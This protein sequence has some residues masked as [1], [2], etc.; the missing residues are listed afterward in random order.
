MRKR[1]AGILASLLAGAFLCWGQA[2]QTQ[3]ILLGDPQFGMYATNAGVAQEAA[4]YEFAVATVNRLKPAFVVVLGDLVNKTGDPDQI[5]EFRRITAKVDAAIPVYLLPG[6]HDVGNEPNPETLAAFRKNIGRDYYSFRAGD[7]YGIVLN[8]PLIFAPAKAM[9]DYQEQEAWLRKELETA[10]VSGAKHIILF[11]HHP[12]FTKSA[13]EPD[14]YEN[15]PLERRLPLLEL[16]NKYGVR[17]LFAGHT[18]RNLLARDGQLE[19]VA[20][21]PVGKPLGQDGSGIR[22]VSVSEEG[23]SHRYYEFGKLPDNLGANSS[24]SL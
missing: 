5:R 12:L 22:V 6:N 24:P 14:G 17:T 19:V 9:Q 4:N 23:L 16:L 8:S 15:I 1:L 7:T 20:T 13:R 11:Q 21:A 18:H 2:P 3:F 10:K